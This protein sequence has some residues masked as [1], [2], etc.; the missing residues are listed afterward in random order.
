MLFQSVATNSRPV[1]TIRYSIYGFGRGR[2]A[3]WDQIYARG[4][5]KFLG[6]MQ[7]QWATSDFSR[8]IWGVAPPNGSSAQDTAG[9]SV[10]GLCSSS[11]STWQVSA[12]SLAS[13]CI[14]I[15]LPFPPTFASTYLFWYSE[16]SEADQLL[17][18]FGTNIL[19]YSPRNW[20]FSITKWIVHPFHRN[21]AAM[22]PETR[23]SCRLKW[24]RDRYTQ[25]WPKL[26]CWIVGIVWGLCWK[27]NGRPIK[28]TPTTTSN[29]QIHSSNKFIIAQIIQLQQ[30]LTSAFA[31]S[32]LFKSMAEQ[33]CS[34]QNFV[35]PL[36]D[37]PKW[38]KMG[39]GHVWCK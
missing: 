16:G 24:G 30:I 39:W 4:V 18:Q 32:A 3:D 21:W 31:P 23:N 19:K 14:L 12:T 25:M 2:F 34:R 15:V 33:L 35:L 22:C 5:V 28:L 26:W 37:N 27:S 29:Y 10:G 20:F 1:F 13:L 6:M 11:E 8:N 17:V 7:F 9:T 38:P 36:K